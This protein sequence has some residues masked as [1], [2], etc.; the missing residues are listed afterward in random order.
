MTNPSR[1]VCIRRS[2]CSSVLVMGIVRRVRPFGGVVL[3]RQVCRLTV[4][5]FALRSSGDTQN[6]PVRDT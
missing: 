3:P 4:M 1:T 5:V 2:A 6:R